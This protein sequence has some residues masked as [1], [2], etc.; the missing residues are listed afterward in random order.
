M[1]GQSNPL[2]F[3]EVALPTAESK[4]P[5]QAIRFLIGEIV[6]AGLLS[7]EGIANAVTRVLHRE[8]L[9][10]TA[11]GKGIALPHSKID[12]LAGVVGVIGHCVEPMEWPGALDGG[13][14]RLVCLMLA[15]VSEPAAYLRAL[16]AISRH[17]RGGGAPGG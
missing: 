11:I 1:S 4:T 3:P 14:V 2:G 6:R 15:P 12:G 16:E 7:A 8:S 10:T 17:L 9:G 13:P 5:E